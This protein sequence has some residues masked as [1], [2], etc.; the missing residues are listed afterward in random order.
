MTTKK[1]IIFIVLIVLQIKLDAQ[2]Y[3][4]VL[5]LSEENIISNARFLAMG[6]AVNSFSN[7]LLAGMFNPAGI[8]LLRKGEIN[9]GV[10]SNSFSNSI[11]FFNKS[12]EVNNL[13]TKLNEIGI[14]LPVPTSRGSL[15]FALG[16][17]ISTDFNKVI[18]FDG[19]NNG[20]NS[21]IQDLTNY[22]DDL[23]YNLALS[24]PIY[25]KNN[26]YIKDTTV[27]NGRLN[28][29]GDVKNNGLLKNWFLTAG[30]EIDKDVFLGA[31][32]SI[33]SGEFL[34]V[35]NYCEDDTTKDYY[36]FNVLLDPVEPKSADFQYFY[37]R[38]RLDWNISGYEF[39]IGIL[40]KLNDNINAGLTVR[41]PKVYSVKEIYSVNGK[42]KFKNFE[43][44]NE[45]DESK[46]EYDI[47]SPYEYSA[48]ISYK[49]EN[50]L[51]A[52][53]AK[54]IDYASAEFSFGFDRNDRLDKNKEI[55]D[56]FR[57][58]I[59]INTG[60]EYTFPKLGLTLRAGFMYKPSAFKNDPSEYDKKF[61]TF[62]G[63]YKL[64][65]KV[66]FDIAYAYG[67]WKDFADNYGS[68]IS[69]VYQDIKI[70]NLITTIKYYF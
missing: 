45:L 37:F 11:L 9:F 10:N 64:S 55:N 59:N 49:N 69:R 53:D 43:W 51:L 13:S 41:F 47:T 18:S 38:D 50:L 62:G 21:M 61:I 8:A 22:N 32:I 25:D 52:L 56:L 57:T 30:I 20:N 24:Y 4:D 26:K 34:K 48:G 12:S 44:T 63:G 35:R 68:N 6:N 70:G 7:D 23:A 17:N 54:L 33:I 39:K 16:Y 2:N 14:V 58:V 40:S 66:N 19:F 3:N 1:I 15:T 27:V 31:S 46:I 36:P 67:W 42:S 5:R 29:S 28:Q 65:K 60:G